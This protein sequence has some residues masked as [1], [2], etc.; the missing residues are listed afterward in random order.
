M[1]VVVGVG[2]CCVTSDPENVLITYALGSCVGLAVY[3][4]VAHVG[5]LL[6]FMLPCAPPGSAQSGKSPW[7]YAD[8]GIPMLF[9]EAY[10][11]GAKK[12]RL[13]VRAAGGAQIMDE[14]GIF[15]IGQRNCVALRK[16]LWKAG[17]MLAAE[18]MGGSQARTM[19]LEIASGRVLLRSPRDPGE[20]EL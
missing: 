3:D 17:V 5:G 18:D 14:S 15:N 20:K 7:T 6:H 4:P 1:N 9:R 2:D 11:H 8:S 19:R 12:S 13:R 16:I 10:E